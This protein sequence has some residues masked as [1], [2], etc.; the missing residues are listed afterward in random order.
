V[1]VPYFDLLTEQRGL[2]VKPF[3]P[4]EELR[5]LRRRLALRLHNLEFT[6]LEFTEETGFPLTQEEL[7]TGEA[8]VPE[9]V[10]LEMVVN[11]VSA[12][13]KTMKK[14]LAIWQRSRF[15][16]KQPRRSIFRSHQ[17][18]LNKRRVSTMLAQ[19]LDTPQKGMLEMLHAGLTAL[20]VIGV[21]FGFLS[22][23]RGW[24]S[25]LSLGSLVC[26]SGATVVAIGTAGLFLA[27][28]ADPAAA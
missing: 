19:Y 23:Y 26:A 1:A 15:R 13:K 5:C 9:P 12:M 22:Y 6:G 3:D 14:T 16:A 11:Q 2:P 28:W 21:V 17:R 25:G 27:S 20:G 24:E 7:S 4:L 8:P 18:M 10:S